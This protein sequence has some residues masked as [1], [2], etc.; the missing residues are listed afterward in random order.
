MLGIDLGS[1]TAKVVLLN[2]NFNIEHKK[3]VRHNGKI[4]EVLISEL[5]ELKK[6]VG[7]KKLSIS[8]TGTAGMGL[9]NR[10]D[11]SFVQ[12]VIA[13]SKAIKLLYK[14]A[15]T[16]I[17]L[18]GE[19]AKIIL[20]EEGKIPEMRM[21]GSCAGGTGSFIDQ[22]S[23][24]LNVDPLELNELAKKSN[25][26]LYIASR[27]GVFAKTDV[28]ALLNRGESKEDIAKAVF[29]AVANQ[30]ITT[31][32]SG[33]DI[34]EKVIFAG[35]P[36]TFLSELR[37]SFHETLKLNENKFIL[38]DNSEV[39]VAV[40]AALYSENNDKQYTIDEI[41]NKIKSEKKVERTIRTLEPLFTDKDEYENFK[42][43]HSNLNLKY[44][45]EKEKKEKKNLYIGIDAGSTTTK[46]IMIDDKNNI[47]DSFYKNNFGSPLNV[48]VE[49]LKKFKKYIKNNNL[50]A[51]FSTGYGEEFISKALNLDGGIVE[52]M[53]H[54][55]SGQSFND[56]LS[57]IVDV[58]GQDIKAIKIE[59]KIITDIRLNE[60]CSSG[61][62]SFIETF[63][64]NLNMTLDE[65]VEKAINAKFPVDLGTRC[66]VF[67]NSKVKEALKDGV[68]V[69]D[70]AAGLAYSVVKNA[71]YKVIK[72]KN[73]DELGDNIF[74]QGGTF[75]NDAVL[76]AFEKITGKN[77]YRLN[78][79]EYMGAFG[80][81][82]YARN[83]YKSREDYKTKFN[84]ESI[85]NI[86][87]KKQFIQCKGCGNNCNITKFVFDNNNIFYTGNKCEKYFSNKKVQKDKESINFFKEKEK[88]IFEID[89]NYEYDKNKP[90]IGIP[91]M[92]SIYEHFQFF[93]NL[94]KN[95]GFKVVLSDRTTQKL[96][97]KGLRTVSADNI[98]FPAKISNG[99]VLNL[100]DKKVDRI[101]IPTIIFEKTEGNDAK[102]AYN[103]PI[104]TG[105]GEVLKRNIKTNIPIDTPSL[106]FKYEKGLEENLFKY[107]N[108]FGINRKEFKNAYIL[109]KKKEEKLLLNLKL[110]AKDVIEEAQKNKKI[111]VI[112]LGRPYHMDPMVNAGVMDLIYELGAYGITESDIPELYEMNLD[113]VLPLTQWSYHNRL[114]LASKWIAKQKYDKVLALQLNS[115][116]CGPDAV[117]VDEVKSLVESGGKIFTVLKIDEMSNIGAAKIRIRSAFEALNN[118]KGINLV[119]KRKNVKPYT[120]D[121]QRKTIL[122]P[123]FSKLYSALYE[124]VMYNLG[125]KL[126]TIMNQNKE[127]IDEGLKYVNNDMC[128]PAV[129]VIGDVIKALKSGD[130]DPKNTVVGLSQTGGQCRASNYVPLLKK[131]L[132]DAGFEDTPV[133]SIGTNASVEGLK[134]NLI[135]LLKY[136]VIA[137][138]IGD[139]LLK[140]KLATAPYERHSG[141][142]NRVFSQLLSE[143]KEQM[144]NEKPS[145]KMMKRFL[146]KA[147]NEFN[148]IEVN[149][150]K[151]RNRIGLVGEIYMK[152]NCFVNNE[153]IKRLEND[154]YEVIVPT[155]LK[156]LE[157]DFYS[158]QYNKR[159]KIENDNKMYLTKAVIKNTI[160]HY[161][162][163]SEKILS[164]FIRYIPES[165]L[166]KTI[167]SN[168]NILPLS[169][170][171]GEGW[172]LANE[173]GDM[174]R[175]GIKNI[176]SL[177]PFGCI[178]NH[179][180]AKGIYRELKDKLDVNLLLLD[181]ESGTSEINII[182]RLK[183]F[184]ETK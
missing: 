5:E 19:D 46:L 151:K 129:V 8:I 18:G 143:I 35:G 7:N 10:N 87:Y 173:I 63:A 121:D 183:L 136:S 3:Y 64:K 150:P 68:D 11:F 179:I 29:L 119:K 90:V 56:K 113:G 42:M 110:M 24:L 70:I 155:F 23:V 41:I 30:T 86:E 134:I 127:A 174:A 57:F 159:E 117:V 124:G 107:V 175:E 43:R 80:A 73:V 67:M 116:G 71:L 145:K 98:C 82:I 34:R 138:S 132:I 168:N 142:T 20:F 79:S 26:T 76:R 130:V 12:E 180:I 37:K 161:R 72:L 59:N 32:L 66:S 60:A 2:K 147:V 47:I 170:Q 96:Y 25:K 112:V 88:M 167:K 176:I 118:T 62:G 78:I 27:C 92:L 77:V 115:F 105:Y 141:E 93:Y 48:A 49:G 51:V 103:C 85:N 182:N 53:A 156:F 28:Q 84:I 133:I 9:A 100:I 6:K 36:L 21:N 17:E 39:L 40:G 91:R 89:E 181:Y 31:L 109:A 131:A 114:Y 157:Y 13:I 122:V 126:K 54:F 152:T 144:F 154:G 81:A 15:H 65:F 38:P 101:F 106:S 104:V 22:M 83:L 163:I 125:Y 94:F 140:L 52:T 146:I 162:N 164:N 108:K 58:G 75:K 33:A 158:K 102:N 139:S 177:Q 135:K 153:I 166:G 99:H 55:V 50:K 97:Y 184:L 69:G 45:D 172:L 160:D 148:K 16:L 61:T 128:Y 137:F 74:V 169:L 4:K 165:K 1:A 14:E 120:K 123:K 95:L 171:F 44:L 111:L 149:M 178:S